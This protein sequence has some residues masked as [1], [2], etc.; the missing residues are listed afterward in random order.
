MCLSFST[1]LLSYFYFL[2]HTLCSLS[3]LLFL[4]SKNAGPW[5]PFLFF[6][7]GAIDETFSP[8]SSTSFSPLL[9]GI[10]CNRFFLVLDAVI[11]TSEVPLPSEAPVIITLPA[12]T[13]LPAPFLNTP[14]MD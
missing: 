3:L 8:S 12:V 11:H 5:N 6:I 4:W 14:E 1:F 10:P 2:T 9:F 7:P 13:H